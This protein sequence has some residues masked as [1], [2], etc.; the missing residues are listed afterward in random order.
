MLSSGRKSRTMVLTW[1]Q[2]KGEARVT[3]MQE[4][5]AIAWSG[6]GPPTIDNIEFLGSRIEPE[7]NKRG[8]SF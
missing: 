1:G 6:I 2:T 4:A 8:L 3:W 5:W 7:K